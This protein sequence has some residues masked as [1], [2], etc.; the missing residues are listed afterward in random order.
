MVGS[1]RLYGDFC[2]LR[3]EPEGYYTTKVSGRGAVWERT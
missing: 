3:V 1:D 2:L